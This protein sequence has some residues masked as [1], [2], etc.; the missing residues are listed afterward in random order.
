MKAGILPIALLATLAVQAQ[1]STPFFAITDQAKGGYNWSQVRQFNVEKQEEPQ[2]LINGL[3]STTKFKFETAANAK[4][5][6]AGVTGVQSIPSLPAGAALAYDQSANK[7]YFAPM[8]SNGQIRFVDLDDKSGTL[9]IVDFEGPK[10]INEANNLT[11]MTIGRNG[12][13]YALS[14]DGNT[15]VRFSTDKKPK[16]EVLGGL[17]DDTK[18]GGISVHNQC[19]SW[20]GDIIGSARGELYLFT[21]RNNVFKIDPATRIA[22]YMGAITGLGKNFSLNGAAVDDAGNIVLSSAISPGEKGIIKNI[23]S[24]EATIEKDPTWYN[25]SDLASG[26]LLFQNARTSAVTM[27]LIPRKEVGNELVS[28]YPNPVTN[29]T[30]LV[31][32]NK[33][34]PGRYGIDLLNASGSST[35]QR[36]VEITTEGQQV[37]LNIGAKANGLYVVRVTDASKKE[38]FASKII[39][40]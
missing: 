16:V 31:T 34:G 18:N 22:T 15:F 35:L 2:L 39:V 14:N 40:Q 30:V 11:R 19:S 33:V 27:D 8:F 12:F 6:N 32:F 7:L 26:N 17:I 21:M 37:K 3:Q 24:L 5:V 28:V 29:G 23:E 20:G 38:V 4:T 25:A 36:T 10:D 13:G 9:H 1:K